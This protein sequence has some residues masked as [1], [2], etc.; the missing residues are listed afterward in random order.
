MLHTS[1]EFHVRNDYEN[2]LARFGYTLEM[3]G[4]GEWGLKEIAPPEKCINI[5]PFEDMLPIGERLGLLEDRKHSFARSTPTEGHTAAIEYLKDKYND[6]RDIH[7]KSQMEIV[8][9][10]IKNL[11]DCIS[12]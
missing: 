4:I 5:E 9:W 7:A 2:A 3:P 1:S 8:V 6:K 11:P 12:L 10:D